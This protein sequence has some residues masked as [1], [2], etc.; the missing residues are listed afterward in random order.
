MVVIA[1]EPEDMATFDLE[2]SPRLAEKLPEAVARIAAEIE[3]VGGRVKRRSPDLAD[4][5]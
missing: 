5:T 2:L 3:A 4:A 1:I